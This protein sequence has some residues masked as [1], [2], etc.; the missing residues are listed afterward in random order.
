MPKAFILFL[1]VFPLLCWII[2][3]SASIPFVYE[4]KYLLI[5]LVSYGVLFLIY[6]CFVIFQHRI[7][8]NQDK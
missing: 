1:V 2:P 5:I 4:S 3:V 7:E 6:I 8:K